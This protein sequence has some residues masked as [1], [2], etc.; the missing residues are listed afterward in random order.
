M[1]VPERQGAGDGGD[2]QRGIPAPTTPC[3][4]CGGPVP[5]ED[6]V[7][8]VT[9]GHCRVPLAVDLGRL[10]VHGV[11]RPSVRERD[12]AGTVERWLRQREVFADVV[13]VGATLEFRP[14]YFVT[15]ADAF[16]AIVQAAPDLEAPDGDAARAAL[17]GGRIEPFAPEAL[18]AGEAV[19]PVLLLDDISAALPQPGAGPPPQVRLVHV[20][21]WRVR[22]RVGGTVYGAIVD[23]VLGSVSA[24]ALPPGRTSSLDRS[25]IL[26]LTGAIVAATLVALLLSIKLTLLVYLCAGLAAWFWGGAKPGPKFRDV[27]SDTPKR[28]GAA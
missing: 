2:A 5:L 18:G 27:R 10:L 1:G 26:R 9:C 15:G 19:L 12:V 21:L 25:A 14:F 28:G 24:L 23:G 8:F 16:C 17:N 11:I 22:Y 4:Q 3:S 7:P 20:P 6:G 13:T